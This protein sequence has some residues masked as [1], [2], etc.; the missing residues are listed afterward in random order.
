[1]LLPLDRRL[2]TT[3]SSRDIVNFFCCTILLFC[4]YCTSFVHC[5]TVL[6]LFICVYVLPCCDTIAKVVILNASNVIYWRYE[7]ILAANR[8]NN[9]LCVKHRSRTCVNIVE[10]NGERQ[11]MTKYSSLSSDSFLVYAN[12]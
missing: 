4:F 3:T 1:M 8:H 9:D 6:W 12:C 2:R 7:I 11:S 10:L 5:F